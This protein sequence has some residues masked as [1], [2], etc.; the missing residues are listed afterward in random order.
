[1]DYRL[2]GPGMTV[3][4]P[5]SAR[6]ALFFLGNCHATQGDGEIVCTG[7]ETCFEVTVRL[8]VIALRY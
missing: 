1:M 3:R 2:L 6:S 7:I 5:V 4:F 8:S